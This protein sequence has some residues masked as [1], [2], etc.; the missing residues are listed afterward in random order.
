M[1]PSSDRDG[2]PRRLIPRGGHDPR[3]G[4]WRVTFCFIAG[5]VAK[6]DYVDYH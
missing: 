3:S 1:T 4:N 5:E 6:V 2:L